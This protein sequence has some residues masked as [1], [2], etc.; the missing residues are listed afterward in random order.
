MARQNLPFIAFNR[1]II[2]SL[3]LARSDIKRVALSA[4]IM[5][6]WMA[7]TLGSMMLRPGL[8]Y[9]GTTRHNDAARSFPFVFS[10]TQKARLELTANILRVWVNDA[11]VTRTLVTTVVPNGTWPINL[12]N[13]TDNDDAGAASTWAAGGYMQLLGTGTAAAIRDCQ[14]PVVG[15]NIGKQHGLHVVVERGPVTFMVGTAAGNDSYITETELGSGVHSLTLTPTGDFY[16]RFMST[17]DRIILVDQCAIDAPG[18]AGE[19]EVATPWGASDLDDVR[20]EQSGDIVYVAC[21]G[22]QQYKIER[23]STTSWSVVKYEPEDGP[24]RVQNTTPTTITPS[25]LFGNGTLAASLPIF[26]VGHVGALFAV[27]S[28]G[29]QVAKAMTALNDATPSIQVTGVTTSRAFTIVLTGLSGTGNTVVLQSSFDDATWADV[30]G[31]SW[32]VDTQESYTDGLDNQVIY[33]RLLCTV[34]A[35]GTTSATLL[36]GTGTIRGIA[37]VTAYSAPTLVSMEVLKAF[38]AASASDTWEEGSWSPLRGWPSSVA[39]Y[40][41]R[42]WWAGNDSMDGSVSDGYE[43]YDHTVVGDSGPI[44]RSI[45]RGPVE[46][47]NWILPLQRLMLGGQAAENSCRSNAFDEPL[48]PTNFNI[49]EISSQG[50]APVAAVKVDTN[51]IFVQRGGC[52]V[53]ELQ[54]DGGSLDYASTQ[55]SA[56]APEI[57]D[58][59]IV[60]MAVQR[61]PDTRV[62]CVRSDGT[63]A[64]LVFD[65]V[66]NVICW[67]EVESP[68]A[69][70]FIEDVCILPNDAGQ[71]EDHVYYTV[72]RTINGATVRYHERWATEAECRGAAI[73]LLADSY[74]TG[75]SADLSHLEGE[76]VVVWSDGIAYPETD[77]TLQYTVVSGALS[78]AFTR[79][80]NTTVGLYYKAQWKGS[81]LVQL[82]APRGTPLTQHKRISAVG[83]ILAWTHAKGLKFGPDFTHLDDLPM[84][85]EGTTVGAN[86]VWDTY[87]HEPIIFPSTW[88]TDARLCL[89]AAAPR[90]CTVLAAIADAEVHD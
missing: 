3:A 80:A 88:D 61:Q 65:K 68:S 81:K 4:E 57:G 24:F 62:H 89:E 77:T 5:V 26:K 56:L 86:D 33:Y 54:I 13:W 53:F 35:G 27:T 59:G 72:R 79:T 23:R 37:R 40:E 18:S 31:K 1:G 16:I 17:L 15:A 11:L 7:R 49:K 46:T 28:V 63:A 76:Q 73:C 20:I 69:G 44:S 66:E 29:Q 36:I 52:R 9:I 87:D 75:A 22:Q 2:S 58:P 39:L 85:E 67:L 78:P 8:G 71:K 50:S 55:L 30:S 45:G 25:V 38:G 21:A 14:V 41:G 47:I 84:I 34:Y 48:T 70:G 43:S 51:G 74:V 82:Q 32:I 60:R 90:P 19:M 12:N 10:I 42:L 64:V 6:N 83:L